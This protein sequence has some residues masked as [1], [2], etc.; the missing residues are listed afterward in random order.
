M[1]TRFGFVSNSSSSSFMVAVPKGKTNITITLEVDLTD[2]DSKTFETVEELD[3]YIVEEYG[4]KEMT[5]EDI[6]E[7][8]GLKDVYQDA[9]EQIKKG[10][11]VISGRLR[12]Y[13][14]SNEET[15]LYENGFPDNLK[16]IKVIME[17][18]RG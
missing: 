16:N 9:V 6:L 12:S 18:L 4:W 17:P 10:K 11:V 13:G 5:L 14:G 2:F 7:D 3:E 8:A 15:Y 1:K